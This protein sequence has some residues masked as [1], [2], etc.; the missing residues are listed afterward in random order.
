[1]KHYIDYSNEAYKDRIFLHSRELNQPRE[2]S[3]INKF[4]KIIRRYSNALIKN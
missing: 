3:F 4:A 2:N 1:M